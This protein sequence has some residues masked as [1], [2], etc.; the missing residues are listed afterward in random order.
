MF[1]YMS[2][3]I[4]LGNLAALISLSNNVLLDLRSSYPLTNSNLDIDYLLIS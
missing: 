1:L 4:D 2:G 3:E